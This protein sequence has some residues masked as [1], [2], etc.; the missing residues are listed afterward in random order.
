MIRSVR[1]LS[2][3]D[4]ARACGW[5]SN[6]IAKFELGSEFPTEN[7]ILDLS[8][9]VRVS[10]SFFEGA[11]IA[12]YGAGQASF[13]A[14]A[15]ITKKTMETAQA[16]MSLA[17]IVSEWFDTRVLNVS[18]DV[19]DLSGEDPEQAAEILRAH[20]GLGHKGINN[21][22]HVLETKGIRF[23]AVDHMASNIDAFC[24]WLGHRP[25]IFMRRSSTGARCRFDACHELGHLVLHRGRDWG[26]DDVEMEKEADA[27]ASAFLMPKSAILALVKPHTPFLN[28]VGLKAHWK[29]SVMALNRRLRDVGVF[30]DKRYVENSKEISRRGW[31]TSEP[32]DA[33]FEG[34]L[35]W[36]K[37]MDHVGRSG[38][39]ISKV[40]AEIG[41]EGCDIERMLTSFVTIP[42]SSMSVPR[43]QSSNRGHLGWRANAKLI[44]NPVTQS[45]SEKNGKVIL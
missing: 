25:A 41:L 31:R 39:S 19:P 43:S 16:M 17:Q 7:E 10:P 44:S 42:A 32:E 1:G 33:D 38:S 21:V 40:A 8:Q 24:G 29:V 27:F 13:R 35:V 36:N 28:L 26:K 2:R 23:F 3:I 4:L 30:S 45:D 5:P 20:W 15:S 34:S 6:M 12:M 9:A 14:R 37:A 22:I 18:V 11:D